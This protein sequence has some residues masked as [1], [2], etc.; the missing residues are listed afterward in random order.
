MGFGAAWFLAFLVPALNLGPGA[1]RTLGSRLLYFPPMGACV[2]GGAL[3]A[4]WTDAP[5]GRRLGWA[6]IGLGL[7]AAVPIGW[8]QMQPWVQTS[9][10]TQRITSEVG[11]IVPPPPVS[12][13]ILNAR[14]V[15]DYYRGSYVFLNGFADALTAIAGLPARVTRVATLDPAALQRSYVSARGAYNL[16]LAFDPADQ[17]YHVSEFSG[18]SVAP[19]RRPRAAGCGITPTARPARPPAG[20]SGTRA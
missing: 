18:V 10:Q 9:R 8:A 19:R 14:G 11:Q 12:Y 6:L 15:P 17:L 13:V 20:R 2:L 16:G 1:A 4:G 3:L 7:L 5:A